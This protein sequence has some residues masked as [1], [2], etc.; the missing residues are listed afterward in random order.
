MQRGGIGVKP[1]EPLT[2]ID[3]KSLSDKADDEWLN[4]P[5]TENNDHVVRVSVL[6]RDFHWHAH[7]NSDETFLVLEGDLII[8]LEGHSLNLTPGQ[9]LTVPKGV[10]H[11]TRANGRTVNLTF[12]HRDTDVSGD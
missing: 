5:L 9:M 7:N 4:F 2:V 3:I 6:N 12:E 11:R 8:D 1:A 10:R